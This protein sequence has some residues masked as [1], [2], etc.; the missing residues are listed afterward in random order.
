MA[1]KIPDSVRAK[2]ID[3]S[4]AQ[5]EPREP[6][7]WD[8][9]IHEGTGL[10]YHDLRYKAFNAR[11]HGRSVSDICKQYGV[12]RGSVVKWTSIGKTSDGVRGCSELSFLALPMYHGKGRTVRNRIKDDVVRIRR[13]HPRMGSAKIGIVGKLNA[14]AGTIDSV[15]RENRMLRPYKKRKRKTYV[16]FEREHSMSLWQLDYKQ[17]PDGLWS[18]WIWDD[19]SRMI[20]GMEVTMSAADTVIRLLESTIDMFGTPKQ[21]LTDHGTQFT[22]NR[23]GEEN[24]KF[25]IWCKDT[26]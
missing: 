4:D 19:H 21:I 7:K 23:G 14:S 20:L 24:H 2:Q 9:K 10:S 13:E 6:G 3:K 25:E 26:A 16:R 22:N 17:W 11:K 12:S 1:K 18:I 15:L 5:R 8:T